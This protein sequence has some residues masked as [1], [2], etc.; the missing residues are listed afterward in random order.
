MLFPE[1][2]DRVDVDVDPERER[3]NL[4]LFGS[5]DALAARLRRPFQPRQLY[6]GFTRISSSRTQ[7]GD[8]LI[9]GDILQI[10][11]EMSLYALCYLRKRLQYFYMYPAWHNI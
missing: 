2:G 9:M 11:S 3:V 6:G 8:L 4:E 7:L 10:R 1:C 5:R